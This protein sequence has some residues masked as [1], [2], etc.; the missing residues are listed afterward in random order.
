MTSSAAPFASLAGHLALAA[1][2]RMRRAARMEV[3]RPESG[4]HVNRRISTDFFGFPEDSGSSD[5]SQI[6]RPEFGVPGSFER[7]QILEP[8]SGVAKDPSATVPL[9][10][11]AA[12]P[13]PWSNRPG[14]MV[15]LALPDGSGQ[16]AIQN[17]VAAGKTTRSSLPSTSE[18]SG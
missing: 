12:E 9:R 6:S 4:A 1:R 13:G 11:C 5:R 14:A 16:A 18:Y 7:I 8:L 17:G 3:G 2:D 10:C 15:N